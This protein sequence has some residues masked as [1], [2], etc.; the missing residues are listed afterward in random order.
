MWCAGACAALLLADSA[1]AAE[2]YALIVS[3]AS[4]GPEYA[5]KYAKWRTSLAATL[6]D[7]FGYPSDHV[8]MLAEEESG[9]TR[10]ATRD[11]VRQ[12]VG[13][14]ASRLGPDDLLLI[15]LIGHGTA[16]DG[17]DGKFN[18]VGPDL[19]A[20]DWAALLKPVNGPVIFVNTASGSFPFLRRLAGPG[21]LVLTA[22]DSAA[23]EFETIFPGYFIDALGDTGADADKNGRVSVW[24]A[25]VWASD[26]VKRS[27]E[28]RGQLATER[29]LL[30]DTGDGMGREATGEGSDGPTAQVTYLREDRPIVVAGDAE[31]TALLRQ[32]AG[33]EER[34]EGLRAR[35]SQLPP[36]E[37]ERALEELLLEIARLDRQIR[38]RS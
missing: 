23:Q 27:F 35:K 38:S 34:L 21:R 33:L 18:L 11:N 30:D 26:G 19:T 28:Q 37:Y 20:A 13:R 31:L 32:R 1:E 36:E 15:V 4:G 5:A 24:E 3:G 2:R 10:R 7:T 12:E 6:Q 14:L 16:A 25:F 17:D 9:T 29:A 22:N 8:R